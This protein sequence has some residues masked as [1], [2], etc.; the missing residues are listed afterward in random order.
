[1]NE[2]QQKQAAELGLVPQKGHR[3][4]WLITMVVLFLLVAGGLFYFMSSGNPQDNQLF[5]TD[6][7]SRMDLS[8]TVSATGSV[9][10]KDEVEVSSEL[11]GI[12]ADV[13]VDYN[14]H[15]TK[16]QALA[17]LDTTNLNATVLE[18]KSSLKSAKAS[19][20]QAQ[21]ALEEARLDYQH[22]Q[23]VWDLSNGKHPS[24]QTLDSARIAVTK[25]EAS[26]QVAQ[27]SVEVAAADLESA[28]SD[29]VKATIVSPIDGIVLSKD[30]EPG[31]T[32]AS[33]YSAPTLFL[34][35]KD[36]KNMELHV[37]IDEADI[38]LIKPGQQAT[39]TVDAYGEREFH[40]EI[41]QIRLADTEDSDTTVVSYE[42]ILK[43]DNDDLALLPGMTA[44]TDIAVQSA[45]NVLTI[46]SAAL[47]YTPAFAGDGAAAGDEQGSGSFFSLIP[48]MPRRD[49]K[50][51]AD[52][53]GK[54]NGAAPDG[55]AII[56]VL[57]NNHPEAVEVKTGIS[58]GLRTEIVSG[59][60][61]ENDV[62]II[63]AVQVSK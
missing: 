59:D 3:R 48:R 37:D 55:S 17:K 18:K 61:Q 2:A 40:A 27:A 13:Y 51:A 42:T 50:R 4:Y 34:L 8:V 29:L 10:P 46:A 15:V 38:G 36:L 14:D 56:W 54:G 57:R 45:D 16:N 62:V 35:A 24:K 39:F 41:T 47:R 33:S 22:Y 26:L 25:A 5:R 43:V 31:Q 19:V 49:S 23:T 6:N 1:M 30:V 32:I 20:S 44:V 9:E 58:N 52:E 28:E 21:A 53:Q 11:S 12:M 63:D 7:V 60:L